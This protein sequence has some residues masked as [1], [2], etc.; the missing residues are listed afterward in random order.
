MLA[1]RNGN[2]QLAQVRSGRLGGWLWVEVGFEVVDEGGFAEAFLVE[3]VAVAE[4]EGAVFFEGVEVN[5]D[6]VGGADFVLAAVAAADGAGGVE[7]DVPAVFEF[8]VE[9]FG[10]GEEFGFVFDEG[11]DGGFVGGEAGVE[12]QE[13]AFFAFD[14]VFGVGG[15]E[16]GEEDA[17]D[18]EGGF[19][20]V[21]VYLVLVASSK[22]SMGLPLCLP[23]WAR[24]KS[25]RTAVPWS[26]WVPKGNSNMMSVVPLE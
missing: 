12:A 9:G 24:S 8:A 2:P 19:D 1:C 3:G 23:C 15:G 11:E 20:D 17:V 6:G 16:D 4:G 26:S 10:V 25:P 14:F 7:E 21:G 22:Y 5:G 13:G 18:A